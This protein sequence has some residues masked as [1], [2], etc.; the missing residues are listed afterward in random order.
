MGEKVRDDVKKLKQAQKNTKAE[1]SKIKV[2]ES[3]SE[4]SHVKD[5]SS[6][7]DIK[8]TPPTRQNT[9][10][11]ILPHEIENQIIRNEVDGDKDKTDKKEESKALNKS[12]EKQNIEGISGSCELLDKDAYGDVTPPE[13][14]DISS[15]ECV[16]T[17]T[18]VKEENIQ[19][20]PKATE[21]N[22]VEAIP[23]GAISNINEETE[24]SDTGKVE[25]KLE[26]TNTTEEN[27]ETDSM[28]ENKDSNSISL[29]LNEGQETSG[30]ELLSLTPSIL[31]ND[32]ASSAFE[33]ATFYV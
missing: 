4:K 8:V 22:E 26:A 21:I 6:T 23:E 2:E 16:P 30:N 5:S 12:E 33:I 31:N 27:Q 28:V 19:E 14:I 13:Q 3:V 1:E 24:K 10:K 25:K 29:S 11:L 18:I 20:C 17:F 15:I 7:V 32:N 9:M